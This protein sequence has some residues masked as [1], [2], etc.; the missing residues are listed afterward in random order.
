MST[1]HGV[2][3]QLYHRLPP[4]DQAAIRASHQQQPEAPFA[5]PASPPAPAPAPMPA[6]T[7]ARTPQ[8]AVA[9]LHAL[10]AP[11]NRDL[12]GLS[13]S[14]Q[15]VMANERA[16]LFNATRADAAQGALD[17]MTPDRADY[18]A[19]PPAVARMEYDAASTHFATDPYAAELQ[20]I[21]D[22]ATASPTTVPSYLT[23]SDAT[24]DVQQFA[25]EQVRSALALLGVELPA[26]ASPAQLAGG[27][28]LLAT[29]PDDI[30]ATLLNPGMQVSFSGGAGLG[31]P[32]L[33]GPNAQYAVEVGTQLALGDLQTGVDFAQTQQF[34]MSVQVQGGAV[35]DLSKTPLQRIYKWADRLGQLPDAARD[36]VQ[37]SPVLQQVVKGLPVS[38][39]YSTFDGARLG[40][41]A[42][43]TPQQG[44]L[45]ADGDTAGMPNPLDPLAMPAGTSILMRGQALSGSTFEA[46]WKAL[47]IGGTT[48]QLEGLGF[49]V[50]R[51]E[52]SMVEVYS[53]AVDTVENSAFFGIGRQ[54]TLA[55]GL[56]TDFS[57]ETRA[58]DVARIDLSTS[59]GQAAYQT[60]IATGQVPAWTPPGVPQSGTT[61]IFSHEYARFAGL[62]VGSFSLGGASDSN[63]TITETTWQDGSVTFS[64]TYT[65]EGGVTSEITFTRDAE[66]NPQ[67]DDATWT[68][69]RADLDPALAS[70]LHA[71]YNPTEQNRAFD[72]PQ[73][74]QMQLTTADLLALRDRA[75]DQV[76]A[77]QGQEKLDN[78]DSG[79]EM[80]WWTSQEESLAVATTP[81]AVFSVLSKDFHG[82]AVIQSLMIMGFEGGAVDGQ[83]QMRDAG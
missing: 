56:G 21:V 35:A 4:E 37:G 38:G 72:G 29:V 66:G 5:A 39:S 63:G 33:I 2:S 12:A 74:A 69:V 7:Q 53:G 19:L 80:P 60:F 64:D 79:V 28:D 11:D 30:L 27:Y 32:N 52:G 82:E 1:I 50:T 68:V 18:A 62:Q 65:S 83:L 43:V 3:S 20:R 6:V 41:E 46:N 23:A 34:E 78:L 73:H 49:G 47:T 75:R 59:E 26:D 14:V 22:E 58:M 9:A 45:L 25:P 15:Q 67:Y 70:Y 17:R 77:Q 36:L 71:A 31:T 24:T 42:V 8:E 48:T 61:E 55:V 54:G 44:A 10:P 57:M 13:P 40:Y 76:V 16:T 51:G 81:E